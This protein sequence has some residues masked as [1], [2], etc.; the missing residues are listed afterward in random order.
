MSAPASMAGE[1][2]AGDGAALRGKR[3]GLLA[4][5]PLLRP[6][7]TIGVVAAVAVALLLDSLLA[8]GLILG[9]LLVGALSWPRGEPPGLFFC[10]MFQGMSI[11]TGY[12]Y[13]AATGQ[14][15]G[16]ALVGD[17]D[18]AVLLILAGFFATALGYRWG[19]RRLRPLLPER[20]WARPGAREDLYD[21]KVLAVTAI[22]LVLLDWIL[23]MGMS[24]T[25][26]TTQ[27]RKSLL[28]IRV[29]LFL[30]LF[31]VVL[32][33]KRGWAWA[34][35]AAAFAAFAQMA[36]EMSGFTEVFIVFFIA[37][38]TSWK[39]GSGGDGSG[40]VRMVPLLAVAASA[41]VLG[42]RAVWWTGYAK[43]IWRGTVRS[44]Y[45]GESTVD[46][47][48]MFVD[49]IAAPSLSGDIEVDYEALPARLSSGLGF[50]SLVIERV[51]RVIDHE[52]GFL[53]GRALLHVTRPRFLFPDKG[54]LG[55][56]SW[57]VTRYAGVAAA[58]ESQGTSIGLGYMTQFYIDF[59]W[60][61]GL[62]LAFV[63]GLLIAAIL[64]TLR[65]VSPSSLLYSGA[66]TM[67]L[68]AN[69]RN[70]DGE[71][72]KIL[73]GLI[74]QA[75]ILTLMLGFLGPPIHRHFLRGTRR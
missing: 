9:L 37:A 55:G 50:T 63:L 30:I 26:G 53:T 31:V 57:L 18:A 70:Y 60:A 58:D 40:R 13:Y 3:P 7:L 19:S 2:P 24:L 17:V 62:A 21:V 38:L 22:G 16:M 56:D 73:G 10:L 23:G 74:L 32:Q 43:G 25:A 68:L 59:G 39:P 5:T 34:G 29:L 75:V 44:G 36:S 8:G 69:F 20:P 6:A 28:G 61:G 33:R 51:P 4:E 45:A 52:R 14:F 35:G 67:I 66:A 1:R 65:A 47:S 49:Q 12:L 11:A 54:N 15:P 42:F 27:I 71:L 46:R 64:E 48:K 72:A 41:V